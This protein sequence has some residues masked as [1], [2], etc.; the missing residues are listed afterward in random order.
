MP[1]SKKSDNAGSPLHDFRPLRRDRRHR[2]G[3]RGRAARVG[4]LPWVAPAK[5]GAFSVRRHRSSRVTTLSSAILQWAAP[6]GPAAPAA[7]AAMHP[8]APSSSRTP[9]LCST[10][11]PSAVTAHWLSRVRPV[12]T[13]VPLALEVPVAM[14][15]VGVTPLSAA[16]EAVEEQ[17]HH[18]QHRY[19]RTGR[20]RS[21]AFQRPRSD[22][23]IPS[24]VFGALI[25][26][27]ISVL[28]WTGQAFFGL[29]LPCFGFAS[30]W[31]TSFGSSL[32]SLTP[33]LSAG[34]AVE[35]PGTGIYRAPTRFGMRNATALQ[36][37]GLSE[38][39]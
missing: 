37:N 27:G 39:P 17:P 26:F 35:T 29:E 25:G 23:P 28:A 31:T 6:A 9:T 1:R 7:R 21:I 5:A 33:L 32:G 3:R 18:R 24:A 16:R 12:A 36:A 13:A 19:D 11:T 10:P 38:T 34:S 14:A 2:C 22:R 15:P 4:M 8:A 20:V 30:P